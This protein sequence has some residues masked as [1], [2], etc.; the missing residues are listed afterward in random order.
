L[1]HI[2]GHQRKK[3][4]FLSNGIDP[5]ANDERTNET[6]NKKIAFTIVKNNTG[7]FFKDDL[8]KHRISLDASNDLFLVMVQGT[9]I[10]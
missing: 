6:G 7:S 4:P 9:R 2:H 10:P 8:W 5:K 1:D 3:S